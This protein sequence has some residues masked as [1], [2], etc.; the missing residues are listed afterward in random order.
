MSMAGGWIQSRNGEARAGVWSCAAAAVCAA[1]LLSGCAAQKKAAIPWAT[2]ILV[3]PAALQRT[4]QTTDAMDTGDPV[5]ELRL[6]IPPLPAPLATRNVPA[7]PRSVAP[8][9]SEGARQEKLAPPQIVPELSAGESASLQ[10]E[11]EESLNAAERNLSSMAGKSLNATQSDLI[12][13]V[14]S[15]ISDAREAAR[16]GDWER[17]RTL[18]TKAQV[19]SE[20]LTGSL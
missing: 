18:A 11:T 14:R 19:L 7:R 16:A 15:F 12:S 3:R 4:T 2:A 6:E 20:Q 5:P 13:K 1:I 10:R 17:A 9:Q 8:T